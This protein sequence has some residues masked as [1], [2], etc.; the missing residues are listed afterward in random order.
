MTHLEKFLSWETK[1]PDALFLRQPIQGQWRT[2]TYSEAGN[3]IRR[4]ASALLSADLGQNSHIA[5]LS[6]NCAH[7]IM[8]DLAIGLAGFVSVPI[9]PTL[10][11]NG[12][13]Y[14]LEHS[15]SKLI[16]LGKLD[17]FDQQRP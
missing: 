8:A 17:S 14:I 10:S 3:E 16:F 15:N 2:W 12:V 5:I 4:M 11:A 1:T 9:Y 7:W 6:K 13:K